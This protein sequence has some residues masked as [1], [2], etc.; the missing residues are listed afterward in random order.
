[1]SNHESRITHH[2]FFV[3]GTDTGVG[4]TLVTC[5]LLHAFAARGLRVVGMK[6]VAAGARDEDGRLINEDVTAIE[7]ASNVSAPHE[8][9]NPYCFAA[10]V[11]PHIA[12]NEARVSIDLAR[13]QSAYAALASR[14]D[15]VIV[16]GAGGFRVPLGADYDTGDLASSL[17]LP[18][19]LV[20]GM[21][22]GCINHALLTAAAVEAAGL[23]L[24]GWF[25]NHI[26][27][28]MKYA[29]QNVCA[30]E[31]RLRAPLLARIAYATRVDAGHVAKGLDVDALCSA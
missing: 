17:R 3:T 29:T 7:A 28:D 13:L 27:P 2:G 31:E 1:M 6:P 15:C 4:K 30:L 9:V 14:A 8:L 19:L 11:A 22:L 21:R 25:A 18:V 10:P 12:A 26:D 23:R 5:A 20:V 24:A 16:E